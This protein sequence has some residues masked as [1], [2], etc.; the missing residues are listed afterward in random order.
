MNGDRASAAT[1]CAQIMGGIG[2]DQDGANHAE[3]VLCPPHL[4]I[5]VVCATLGESAISVGAQDLDANDN[6]AFTGQ[7]SAHMIADSGCRYVIVGHSE[8]RTLYHE[9]DTL[10]AQKTHAALA[11]GLTPIVCLGETLAQRESG[12]TE[13]VIGRQLDA[14]LD[15]T[16]A[17][18]F[19]TAVVAYE[20]VWA[21]GTGA[22]ATPAQA[23]QVHH[24]IRTR[25]KAHGECLAAE[26]RILYGG[27]MKPEN[28]A[29]LIAQ[30]DIDGGLIGGASL[31][32]ADFLAICTAV[33]SA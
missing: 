16:T 7:I 8:R 30:R 17:D 27:S 4:L 11:S 13:E 10:V 9:S 21:I 33:G 23:Q 28:T 12:N 26:C 6:G 31:N 5:P 20:P 19:S 14:V 32:A 25:I 22:A 3:I 15:V 24:F 2:I 1:L 29:E 18:D